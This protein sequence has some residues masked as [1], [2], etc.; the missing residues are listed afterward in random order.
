MGRVAGRSKAAYNALV[1]IF[2][3]FQRLTVN[4]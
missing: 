4:S 3:N 1:L 2:L